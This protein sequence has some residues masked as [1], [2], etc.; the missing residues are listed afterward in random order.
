MNEKDCYSHTFPLHPLTRHLSW[1]WRMMMKIKLLFFFGFL[2]HLFQGRGKHFPPLFTFF[3]RWNSK[4]SAQ[5][6]WRRRR[7]FLVP[8]SNIVPG[9]EE[10]NLPN[11]KG[12]F[13]RQLDQ[14]GHVTFYD[15]ESQPNLYYISFLIFKV[16]PF[17]FDG[18]ALCLQLFL[19]N[20]NNRFLFV[21]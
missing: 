6:F 7:H 15:C 18:N 17:N 9:H 13:N 11:V 4:K 10:I 12:A 16:A 8:S 5:P 14:P 1:P 2:P 20:C 3:D 21:F 19:S